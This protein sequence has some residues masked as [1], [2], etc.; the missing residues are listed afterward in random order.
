M[1][2]EWS[3]TAEGEA[4]VQEN[5]NRKP[6]EWL[7]VVWAEWVAAI[8]HPKYGI[9]YS[10]E[11]NNK[12]YEKALIR[13][14]KKTDEQLAEFIWEKTSQLRQC[15][16][17][18][19]EAHCCPFG[20]GCHMVGFD[21]NVEHPDG[22]LQQGTDEDSHILH[23]ETKNLADWCEKNITESEGYDGDNFV[24]RNLAEMVSTIRKMR[25]AGFDINTFDGF[26]N[27]PGE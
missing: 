24:A 27:E 22:V 2:W 3:H 21:T 11:L 1:T 7:E 9:G 17:G 20:C 26:E 10:A 12:K 14:K 18:G 5:I 13:A 23:V 4:A 15:T 6:R 25:K 8:P 19:W 16:N